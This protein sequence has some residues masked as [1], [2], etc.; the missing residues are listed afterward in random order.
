MY[1]VNDGIYGSFNCL[2]HDH[3]VV[4]PKLLKVS[5]IIIITVGEKNI[6]WGGGYGGP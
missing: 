5:M 1:Y 6:F 4:T 3:A 2:L